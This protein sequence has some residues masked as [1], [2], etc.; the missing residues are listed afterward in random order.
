MYK[1]PLYQLLAHLSIFLVIIN[2]NIYY[3]LLGIFV[4][5]IMISIGISAGY[6]RLLSHKGYNA[7]KWFKIISLT[8]GTLGLNASALTWAAMHREH[9]AFSDTETDPHSPSVLGV[10]K[11]YFGVIFYQPKLRFAKDLLRDKE[12]MF[13]HKNYFKINIAYDILLFIINPMFVVWFHLL[14]AMI[15]WH[16]EAAINVFVHLPRFGYKNYETQDNSRNSHLLAFLIAGEGYH[17]NHHYDPKN[18]NFAH[19]KN[20]F[21]I[22]SKIINLIRINA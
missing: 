5:F 8:I 20:E 10:L 11:T 4:Y 17:N 13:F 14:P 9:H 12:V 3:F 7:P 15:L 6:H 19:R 21:D 16:A 2:F 22:T 18:S 1:L